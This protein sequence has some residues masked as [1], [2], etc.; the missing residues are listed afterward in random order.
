M[1]QT[2]TSRLR[3]SL[4]IPAYN[5]EG[6]LRAC[7]EA[8]CNQTEPFYE[9]IVVD[10]NSTDRTAA[11][12]REFPVRLLHESRQG[13]LHADTAG[14]N[15]VRGEIIA[16]IDADTVITPQWAA[17]VQIIFGE[18][19]TDA[20]SGLPRYYDLALPRLANKIEHFFRRRMARELRET[21][22]LQGA[23]MAV[24]RRA[25]EEIRDNL[26]YDRRYHE[27][28]DIAIHLQRQGYRVTY[29]ERLV[30]GLS[31]R[32]V[33]VPLRFFVSYVRM[34]SYTYAQH[35]VPHFRRMYPVMASIYLLYL[36]ARLLYRARNPHTGKFS[37]AQLLVHRD[38]NKRIDPSTDG[39][40]LS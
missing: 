17:T 19:A 35:N 22:F 5:E 40:Y 11:I 31:A 38:V 9:I 28:F 18:D 37:L 6:H 20:V 32:A 15:A 7:L 33:D 1:P 25:W 39:V 10:N 12:A 2:N 30:A 23:N 34:N 26:C 3:I 29:D 21:L 13:K 4:V 8:A 27:D 24:R 36:P 16:R 14:F